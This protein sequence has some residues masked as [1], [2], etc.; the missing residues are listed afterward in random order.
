MVFKK[1]WIIPLLFIGLSLASCSGPS[2]VD[3]TIAEN[4]YVVATYDNGETK[5]IGCL[6]GDKDKIEISDDG[7]YI[8]NGIQTTIKASDVKTV[9]FNPGFRGADVIPVRKVFVN[10][11]ISQP[12][13]KRT[14]YDLNGWF[15]NDTK[16][17]FDEDLVTKD[18]VLT[19]SWNVQT[20]VISFSDEYHPDIQNISATYDEYV[21]LPTP[22]GVT[23]YT[24]GGWYYRNTKITSGTWTYDY[25]MQL[26]AKWVANVYTVTMISYGSTTKT[27]TKKVSYGSRFTLPVPTNDYGVFD[28]WYYGDVKLTNANGSSL[29][30]YLYTENITV[31][32]EWTVDVNTIEEFNA[33]RSKAN[34][35]YKLQL[36]IDLSSEDWNPIPMFSGLI[37]GNGHTISGLTIANQQSQI[38]FVGKNTGIIKNLTFSNVDINVP[39]ISQNSYVGAIA[40]KN[41]GTID[42][43]V[44]SGSI[45]V[46]NHISTYEDFTGGISGS[47][48]SSATITNCTNNAPISGINNVGGITGVSSSNNLSYLTNNGTVQAELYAA[49]IV[50]DSGGNFSYCTNNGTISSQSYTAGIVAHGQLFATDIKM[51]RCKNTGSINSESCTGGLIA[52][53]PQKVTIDDCVN[54]ANVISTSTSEQ[55][56]GLCGRIAGL[57]KI[58]NSY[59]IGDVTGGNYTGGIIGSNGNANSVISACYFVGGLSC[60]IAKGG[61][62]ASFPGYIYECYSVLSSNGGGTICGQSK[63]NTMMRNCY[64]S[65]TGTPSILQGT[66]TDVHYDS[67]FYLNSLFYNPAYW[68]FSGT[69]YPTLT[70]EQ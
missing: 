29:Q 32:T 31:T 42:N 21:T 5:A 4:N 19:A 41:E 13:Y 16:W 11:K 23:G 1:L 18:I 2:I 48:G 24:F 58:S 43:C 33:I 15:D 3:F 20:Y 65:G 7:Y 55:I 60:R 62:G 53:F 61:I 44:V 59:C 68:T 70:W 8:V 30:T 25:S 50:S 9:E 63:D 12:D 34:G 67:E 6:T 36:D 52:Y 64:Y 35:G 69:T 46:Q 22:E 49:G 28:G 57:C 54:R 47:N 56:G 37:D 10:T 26:V 40:G 14:G 39:A 17:N 45:V 27:T 38:G 66:Q 51:L